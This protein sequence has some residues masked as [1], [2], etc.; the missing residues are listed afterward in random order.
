[1]TSVNRPSWDTL[2]CPARRP[3]PRTSVSAPGCGGGAEP[4]NSSA[5]GE[6]VPGLPTLFGVAADTKAS[7]TCCGD[8]PGL[9]ARTSAAAPAT[10]GDAI[11]VPLIVFVAVSPVLHADVMPTPG[12]NTSVH[13]PQFE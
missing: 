5:F 4:V 13:V 8:A 10:C 2:A 9:P 1:M 7:R 3:S 6:P 12:A 11:D